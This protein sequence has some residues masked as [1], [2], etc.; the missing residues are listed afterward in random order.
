MTLQAFDGRVLLVALVLAAAVAVTVTAVIREGR[1]LPARVDE[2]LATP[3][4]PVAEP[5]QPRREEHVCMTY[6]CRA[7][8]RYAHEH[9]TSWDRILTLVTEWTCP[10][11]ALLAAYEKE[12]SSP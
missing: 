10:E 2:A 1:K 4:A 5:E 11:C 3:P 6:Q 7:C 8:A 12:L 9:I